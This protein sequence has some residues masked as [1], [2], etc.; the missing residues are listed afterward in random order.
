[1]RIW[2]PGLI[3][4]IC[5]VVASAIACSPGGDQ[6]T[7]Q[8]VEVKRGDV[9]VTVSGS[10]NI[11]VSNEANLAFG[12]GGKIHQIHVEEGDQ[13]KKGETLAQLDADFLE[14]AVVQAKASLEQAEYNLEKTSEP[15]SEEDIDSA[16]RA[17]G[18]AEEYLDYAKWMLDQA[19]ETQEDAEDY[20]ENAEDYLDYVERL[21]DDSEDPD[22]TMEKIA[23]AEAQVR[24]A[25]A[26]LDQAEAAVK[27]WQ[28][29]VSRAESDL[30]DAKQRL[31]DILEGPDEG[32]VEAAE[33]QLQSA[34]QG[35]AEAQKQLYE[36][37]IVAPFDGEVATVNA[38]EGDT[39]TTASPVVNLVDL[40]SMEL[41]V[42]V[43]EIDIDEVK[44]GQ[45][46]IIEI[47]A[48]PSLQLEGE[49]TSISTLSVEMGGVVL[50]D[51]TIS[52]N[53]TPKSG[54]KPG[55]SVSADIIV[56]EKSNVLLVPDRAIKQ[57][58]GGGTV[59]KVKIDGEIEEKPVVTGISDGLN[60]EIVSGL[61]DGE[62]I[63][64]Q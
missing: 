48:L 41:E 44:L 20:L 38:E 2:K 37:T 12:T 3:L 49:I 45:R 25:E 63:V 1:M 53:I 60:T 33:A 6:E 26:Q 28:M 58:S 39:I 5:L 21:P 11:V 17:V 18:L 14:L 54:P 7:E 30:T 8:L 19:E 55:M 27:Q 50:Y 22:T 13:V 15:Y 64:I 35:L 46:A 16:E 40:T 32:A 9:T 23:E 34:T 56:N 51:V 43:D 42:Q 10:G 62:T 31:E 61:T 29:E 47:D 59:V 57:G 24:Q 4:L 52:F 36:A